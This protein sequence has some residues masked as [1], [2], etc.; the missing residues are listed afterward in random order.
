MDKG[1]HYSDKRDNMKTGDLVEFN[2]R[3]SA[4]EKGVG[5]ILSFRQT[6]AEVY[7][8]SDGKVTWVHRSYLR[9]VKKCP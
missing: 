6:V 3:K 7:W 1:I 5:V 8:L 2:K 9:P 4:R